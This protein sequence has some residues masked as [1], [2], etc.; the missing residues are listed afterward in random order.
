MGN[1]GEHA[2]HAA[3][4][5]VT[6]RVRAYCQ[7]RFDASRLP[8]PL[9][10]PLP[11][12]PHVASWRT[13]AVEG[14]GRVFE[15]L[16]QS[17]PQLRIP[18]RA[19]ISQ[20]V[21]Y[22]DVARRGEPFSE[23]LFGG[24]LTLR[25]PAAL[26]LF[27]RDHPMGALPVLWTPDRADFETLV[28]A[29]GC[30]SEP[31]VI[32]PA[33][34]AQLVSGFVNWDRVRRYRDAW[35]GREPDWPGELQRVDTQQPSAFRDR[36]VVITTAPY[37]GVNARDLGL[38]LDEPAWLEASHVVRLEHE[39]TH[40]AT[41]RLYG[42]MRAH[43]YDELIADCMGLTAGLGAYTAR[44]ALTCLGLEGWPVLR[45]DARVQA[46]RGDLE[47]AVFAEVCALAAPAATSLERITTTHDLAA[48]RGRFLLALTLLTLDDLAAAD[49][50]DRFENTYR[51]AATPAIAQR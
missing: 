24:T 25:N 9:V 38:G 6:A 12:E 10:L 17:L 22:G 36:A 47:D 34:N 45:P 44:C 49:A 35:G 40:Y 41:K 15:R 33:V 46:Y 19:G 31:E 18:I 23:R 1:P 8:S 5:S 11:D 30:R 42:A 48:D 50:A 7:Q 39:F 51:A 32:H 13:Y 20:S 43:V 37:S 27:V 3:T 2:T 14:V 21:A 28:R 16:Q 29:L 26:Q 4:P